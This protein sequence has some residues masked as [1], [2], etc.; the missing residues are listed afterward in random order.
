MNWPQKNAWI[1]KNE[2]RG[3]N[4]KHGFAPLSLTVAAKG[5]LPKAPSVVVEQPSSLNPGRIP[6]LGVFEK[7]WRT[8]NGPLWIDGLVKPGFDMVIREQ[9]GPHSQMP[10][11]I[12]SFVAVTVERPFR[13]HITIRKPEAGSPR[14]GTAAG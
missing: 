1:T 2:G 5:S 8:G 10:N 7:I 11:G 14:I 12:D 9:H 3:I 4:P 13:I 6:V